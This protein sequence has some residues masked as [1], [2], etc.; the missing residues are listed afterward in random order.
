MKGG[1]M[2][3]LVTG[4]AGRVGSEVVRYLHGEGFELRLTDLRFRADLPARVIVADLSRRESVYGL[5][6]DGSGPVEAIV[7]LGNIP[8][9]HAAADAQTLFSTNC[10]INFNVFQAA[11]ELGVRKVIFASSVQA[12]HGTRDFNR[13]NPDASGPSQLPYLPIDGD[14]PANPGNAYGLSKVVAE[15]SLKYFSDCGVHKARALQ[16]IT[17][18]LP[19]TISEPWYAQLRRDYHKN[20]HITHSFLDEC[21]AYL[22]SRDAARLMA[23][24]LRTN[25]PGYRCYLPAART[26]MLKGSP[27]ELHRRFY[28]TVSLRGE[29]DAIAS[30]VDTRRITSETGWTPED[31]AQ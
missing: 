20:T 27:G 24:I 22:T 1:A 23:K 19:V 9:I 6:D 25:L 14:I 3:V 7:H 31:E 10:A 16:G 11:V 15:Q 12:I 30:L 26:P 29:V 17:L 13:E 21:F 28:P 8:N 2:K 5:I 4:A 18:R